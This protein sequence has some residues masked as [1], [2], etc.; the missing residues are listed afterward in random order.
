MG[1]MDCGL[2]IWVERVRTG[3]DE[4]WPGSGLAAD[5]RYVGPGRVG[6]Y[7]GPTCFEHNI[8]NEPVGRR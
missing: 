5:G 1:R 2:R 3:W 6:K 4:G 8:Q 7:L